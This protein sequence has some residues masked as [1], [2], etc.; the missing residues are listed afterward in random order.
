M[1]CELYEC[2]VN[3]IVVTCQI[4]KMSDDNEECLIEYHDSAAVLQTWVKTDTMS[5]TPDDMDISQ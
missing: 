2:E 3:G 1:G 5:K 4:V